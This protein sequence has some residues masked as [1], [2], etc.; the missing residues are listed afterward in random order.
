MFLP[1]LVASSA[2]ASTS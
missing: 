1:L 2:C